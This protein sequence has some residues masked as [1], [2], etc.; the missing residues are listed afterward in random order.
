MYIGYGELRPLFRVLTLIGFHVFK[1]FSNICLEI[2]LSSIKHARNN[3]CLKYA[4]NATTYRFIK[5]SKTSR[6][7]RFLVDLNVLRKVL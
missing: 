5:M 3:T 6:K 7:W 4:L 2:G 1:P